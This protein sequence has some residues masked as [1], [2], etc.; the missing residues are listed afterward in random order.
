MKCAYSLA[1][2]LA[3]LPA[4]SPYSFFFFSSS[5]RLPDL[6]RRAVLRIAISASI[7]VSSCHNSSLRQRKELPAG[8]PI[9]AYQL[10]PRLPAARTQRRPPT[11]LQKALPP[12]YDR[13]FPVRLPPPTCAP[14]SYTNM[15]AAMRLRR[16]LHARLQEQRPVESATPR[17]SSM[18]RSVIDATIDRYG[19]PPPNSARH[20]LSD[21]S[22]F[23]VLPSNYLHDTPSCPAS[24]TLRTFTVAAPSSSEHF[25][26]HLSRLD[27]HPPPTLRL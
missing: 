16:R 18:T 14:R 24:R 10:A 2:L 22:S 15:A 20:T 7:P 4:C 1:C 5:P 26:A 13:A 27:A 9:S 25:T 17:R 19:L 8:P 3:C 23:S 6:S 11:P 21:K 12:P